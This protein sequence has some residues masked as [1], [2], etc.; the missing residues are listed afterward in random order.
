MWGWSPV[1]AYITDCFVKAKEEGETQ[2][3]SE[4]K[5]ENKHKAEVRETEKKR[6]KKVEEEDAEKTKKNRELA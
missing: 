6:G 5:R 3:K 2:R 1:L 4:K